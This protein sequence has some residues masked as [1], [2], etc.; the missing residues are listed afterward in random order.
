[1]VEELT[2]MKQDLQGMKALKHDI[3]EETEIIVKRLIE[4]IKEIS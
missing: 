1:M 2:N 3:E 4:I